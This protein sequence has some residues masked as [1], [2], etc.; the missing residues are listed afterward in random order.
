VQV[1]FIVIVSRN[2]GVESGLKT[3][4]FAAKWRDDIVGF[5]FAASE[6]H[7]PASTW[8]PIVKIIRQLNL[9]LTVHSGEGTSA[10][11]ISEVL[12]HMVPDRLGHATK[13]IDD[14]ELM[15]FC[16]RNKVLVEACPTSNV[17]TNSVKRYT[18]TQRVNSVQPALKILP[19]HH[20]TPR[21][22]QLRNSSSRLVSATRYSRFTERR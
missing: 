19:F 16:R 8:L 12:K 13:L 3:A 1:G 15:D 17:V 2:Y 14:E 22:V 9:P 11:H 18:R 21:T 4:E 10:K 5:D 7:Y 6:D 20:L